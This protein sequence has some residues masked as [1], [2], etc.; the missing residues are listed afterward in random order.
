MSQQFGLGSLIIPRSVRRKIFV[1]YHHRGDQGYYD[2][3]TRTFSDTYETIFDNSLER[4][5]DSDNTDY[6]VRRIREN[7]ISGSSCTIVLCG[8]ETPWRKYVDWEIKATLD[9]EHGL[10]GVNLPTNLQNANRN[11]TVSDRLYDNI[12]SG[13]AVWTNWNHITANINNLSAIIEQAISQPSRLI[14]NNRSM[15]D[16]NGVPPWRR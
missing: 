6:V 5:I 2:T 3:L 8:A 11:Y 14:V 4:F 13:Y 1:S 15:M 9:A 16:R 10:I 12:Q 7:Y